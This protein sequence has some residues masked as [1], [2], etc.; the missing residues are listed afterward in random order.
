MLRGQGLGKAS[1]KEGGCFY[2]PVGFRAVYCWELVKL[3][4]ACFLPD[5]AAFGNLGPALCDGLGGPEK[6]P[7]LILLEGKYLLLVLLQLGEPLGMLPE[8]QRDTKAP[9]KGETREEKKLTVWS[10]LWSWKRR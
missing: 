9:G 6:E 4:R 7:A 2:A 5:P 10:L 3:K 8:A 1:H